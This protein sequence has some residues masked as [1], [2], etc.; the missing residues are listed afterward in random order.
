MCQKYH[1]WE[2]Q[3]L[4]RLK[5]YYFSYKKRFL[6][7]IHNKNQSKFTYYQTSSCFLTIIWPLKN[8]LK[9]PLYNAYWSVSINSDCHFN[10]TWFSTTSTISIW[11]I[12]HELKLN[13]NNQRMEVANNNKKLNHSNKAKRLLHG[14]SNHINKFK[15]RLEKYGNLISFKMWL[16]KSMNENKLTISQI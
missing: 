1:S 13:C 15:K 12:V 6:Y 4:K 10:Q 5:I 2:E 8:R 9:T 3:C 7:E 11:F 14:S 16:N